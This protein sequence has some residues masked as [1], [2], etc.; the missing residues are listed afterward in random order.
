MLKVVKQQI[1]ENYYDPNFHGVDLEARFAL[2]EDKIK[3][4]SSD[5]QVIGVIAQA[6]LDLNDSHTLLVPPLKGAVVVY[7]WRMKMIGDACYVTAVMRGS[8]AESKGLRAG[9]RILALNGFEPTRDSLWKMKYYF[10]ELRPQSRVRVT[11]Q[12]PE[13]QRRELEILT[14]LEKKRFEVMSGLVVS[15]NTVG[16]ELG[17]E[18]STKVS[19]EEFGDLVISRLSEFELENGELDKMMKRINSYK[20]LILDLR[21]NPG[22]ETATLARFISYFFDHEIKIADFKMRKETKEIRVKPRKS[23]NFTGNLVV[24][25]DSESTSASEVFARVMQIEKRGK[26]IGD[27][28][29]GMVMQALQFDYELEASGNPVLYGLEITNANLVMTDGKSLEWVGVTPDKLILPT[30]DDIRSHRDPVLSYAVSLAGVQLDPEK[31]GA[32]FPPKESKG[33]H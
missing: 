33:R 23:N 16:P 6:V 4:A 17:S 7:G 32:L 13:G 26:I 9:D 3:E 8:D 15:T 19:Y 28:S 10:Y 21:G 12:T 11:A 2:A 20:T 5:G 18:T 25:V 29:G 27:H 30:A 22:G 24:L 1:K 14:K 31:A